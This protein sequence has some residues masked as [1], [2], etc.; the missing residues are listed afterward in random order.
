MSIGSTVRSYRRFLADR[1]FV[2]H[3]GIA[4]CC[5]CGLFAWIS[6]AAFVLQDIYGLSALAFGMSFAVGSSGYLVG[7]MIRSQAQLDDRARIWHELRLPA[8]IGLHLLH[9]GLGLTI[10]LPAG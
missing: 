5:L 4:A 6:T 1:G 10:P 9:G 7:I 3:L 2:I 8:V